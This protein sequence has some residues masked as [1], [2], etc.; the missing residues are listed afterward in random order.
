M[1]AADFWKAEGIFIGY[2]VIAAVCVIALGAL[3]RP[4]DY[5]FRK[6]LHFVAISSVLPLCLG[7]ELWQAALAVDAAFI[8]IIFIALNAAERLPFYSRLFVEKG[9]HEVI[10]SFISLY[11]MLGIFILLFWAIPE[12]DIKYIIITAVAAWGP[13]DALAAIVGIR[14]GRHFL[15]GRHIEGRKSIEG[16]AAML[17]S[18]FLFTALSLSLLTEQSIPAVIIT[19]AVTAVSAALTELFTLKGRDTVSVPT[20]SATLL[21]IGQMIFA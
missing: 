17:L 12:R 7:T 1:T 2:I 20:V 3:F 16:S 6:M 8:V 9:R 13:G 10:H 19:S 15:T 4:K 18:S 11:M 21:F 5:I 14:F